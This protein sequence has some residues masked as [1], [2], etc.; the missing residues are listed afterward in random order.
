MPVPFLVRG[1]LGRG[2]TVPIKSPVLEQ[3][4]LTQHQVPWWRLSRHKN[5]ACTLLQQFDM[6]NYLLWLPLTNDANIS[7]GS[8]SSDSDAPATGK[9]ISSSDPSSESP[10]AMVHVTSISS[11]SGLKEL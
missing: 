6:L 2:V 10:P 5:L 3:S 7:G 9:M 4:H 11:P 1:V 8:R